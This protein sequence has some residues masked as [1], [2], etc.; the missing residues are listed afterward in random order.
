[1][2][3]PASGA[4]VLSPRRPP[5]IPPR[6]IIHMSK[7]KKEQ[8]H[9]APEPVL[10]GEQFS[11]G[12]ENPGEEENL[13]VPEQF[14]EEYVGRLFSKLAGVEFDDGDQIRE[15][16]ESIEDQD[17]HDERLNELMEE[18][19][20]VAMDM[21]FWALD[22]EDQDVAMDI[23]QRTLKLDPQCF[24]AQRLLAVYGSDSAEEAAVKMRKIE[25]D[26]REALGSEFFERHAGRIAE[27]YV[28]GPFMRARL[29][30]MYTVIQ[31]EGGDQSEGIEL[32]R[33]TL[34]IDPE[35]HLDARFNLLG[36]L[37]ETGDTDGVEELIGQYDG[38][39]EIEWIFGRALAKF[40]AGER[41]A[42]DALLQ[43]ASQR[44]PFALKLMRDPES[45]EKMGKNVSYDMFSDAVDCLES[46]GVAWE[47]TPGALEWIGAK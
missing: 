12:G 38:A 13:P 41:E 46:L 30:L 29:D 22:E 5:A 10:D 47:R 28:A 36:L 7:K 8:A 37:L 27:V 20:E 23:A 4:I 43:E 35:D 25:A 17:A 42:A 31:G 3:I 16:V 15:Y 6:A 21:I 32:C 2:D 24:D 34:D 33:E 26:A 11:D 39:P 9:P 40:Q 1:M 44:N 14:M 18:P 45:G 19:P